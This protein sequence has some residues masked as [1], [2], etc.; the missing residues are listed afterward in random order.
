MSIGRDGVEHI[1][2]Y[3]DGLMMVGED[4][5]R[6]K[7]LAGREGRVGYL[8]SNAIYTSRAL[9]ACLSS[10]YIPAELGISTLILSSE[11]TEEEKMKYLRVE[12]TDT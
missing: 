12:L 11:E 5:R 8:K 9:M 3:V 4:V 7:N 6:R 1:D 2:E 10:F